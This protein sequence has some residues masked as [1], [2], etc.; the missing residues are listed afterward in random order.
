[1]P[2]ARLVFVPEHDGRL[3][4]CAI[5]AIEAGDGIASRNEKTEGE[6]GRPPH[7][8]RTVDS[9]PGDEEVAA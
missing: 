1:V 6:H 8:A 7:D 2:I 3:H 5:D 4:R 9:I